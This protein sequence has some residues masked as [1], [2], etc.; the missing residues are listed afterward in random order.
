MGIQV[1]NVN[2]IVTDNAANMV[3]EVST[4]FGN[5]RHIPCFAHTINLAAQR[6][7]DSSDCREVKNLL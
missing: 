7:M 2:A 5:K 6:S 1:E 4:V 3:K